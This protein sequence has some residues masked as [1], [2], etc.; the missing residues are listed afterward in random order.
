MNRNKLKT[1]APQSRRDFIK[2]VTDRAAFYGLT[3]GKIE[4][5]IEQGDVAVIGGKAFP[6][7]VAAKRRLLEQRIARQGFEQVME[8]MAY[9]WFNR[10][11]AI[12]YMELH[13]YLDHG[14]RVLSTT[15]HTNSTNE[16]KSDSSNSWLP[17]ILRYAEH[18][19][20]PGLKKEEVIDL[21]LQG[22]K[23]EELYRMLLLAQ[24]HALHRAMPFLFEPIDDE[25]EL[26]LPDNL[27]HSDSLI[28]KLVAEIPEEDWQEV[29]IIGWLY[30]FYI[31]EKKDQV[32][33]KVVKSED[34]PA[35]TQL[36]TPKWIVKYLVQN[37]LGRQWMATYPDS[38]LKDQMEYY[39]EPAQQTPEVQ[40]QLKAITPTELNPE[41]LTL[42]DPAC[43]SGHILVEA[44]DL[45][46]AIYQ[47]RGYRAKDIP[48]LILEKNLYGLEIDDRAAQLAAFA[49]M[50]KA[51]ADD[52]RIFEA[53]VQP[54]VLAIQESRGL[55]A[56]EITEALNAPLRDGSR[57]SIMPTDVAL[58][59]DLFKNGKTYGS[60]IRVPEAL[61]L[62]CPA[63]VQ[64]IDD[65][66]AIGGM[67]EQATAR[68]IKSLADQAMIL[69]RR[70]DAVCANPPYM[71]SG[72]YNQ[73][74]KTFVEGEFPDGSGDLYA[75]FAVHGLGVLKET[76]MLSLITIPT[77]L[78]LPTFMPLRKAILTGHTIECLV[79]NGRGIFGPDFGS[80]NFV[81][82]NH[83]VEGFRGQFLGLKVNPTS[84]PT[85][86]E[87]ESR[88]R[89]FS[90][91][92]RTAHDF[93]AVP[94]YAISPYIPEAMLLLFENHPS[95][96]AIA[97]VRQGVKTGDIERFLR[98]WHEVSWDTIFLEC[99]SR[100][101]A[102][103]DHRRWYPCNKG[104][105]FRRWFGNLDYVIDWQHDGHA[106]RNFHGKGGR[107]RSRP[108]N[109]SYFFRAGIT[110]ST[111][112]TMGKASFRV[113]PAGRAFESG[114]STIF[115]KDESDSS[116]ILGVLNSS[117]ATS[118]IEVLSPK[119]SLG[120]GAVAKIPIPKIPN[121]RRAGIENNVLRLVEVHRSD[122][123]S[124]EENYGFVKS[125]LV[126]ASRSTI[127][128]SWDVVCKERT[129][130]IVAAMVAE[131]GI[132]DELLG[133]LGL[134]GDVDCKIERKHIT[135]RGT[136]LTEHVGRLISYGIGC[137]MGRYSLDQP[138]LIYAHSGNEGFDPSR[139][140]KFPADEDGIIPITDTDW[141]PDD[142]ANRFVQFIA[143][144]WPPEHLEEN[145]KFVAESLGPKK[146]ESPRDTIRRY[147]ATG[148]FKHHMKMYKKRP[149]YWL[150]SSGKQ[151]AFECLVYLHRY[152]EGTLA[153]MRTEY[154]IPLQG[155]IDARIEQLKEDI[156]SATSTAHGK[157][158]QKE[159]DKLVKQ[160]AELRKFDE[161]L[162]HYADQ[163]ITL[164]LDD[165]VKVNYGKFGDLL[166]E[167]KAVTGKKK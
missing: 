17:E 142:A 67:L 45:L 106:I 80:C 3:K 90:P 140:K 65:V 143:T 115:P 126:S 87:L 6:K 149:I 108:Q 22:D 84:V 56:K 107:L 2:A 59:I 58:I 139:Y 72:Y 66:I 99:R 113:S 156:A 91:R 123:A 167:V 15:N 18:V 4:P 70:Y 54:H 53:D 158:L 100:D 152:N 110:W 101:E 114:G 77:W 27:L 51:R 25:T 21:K 116:Y 60:L 96:E 129:E 20:L 41:E 157:R 11:V 33:G 88:F 119:V 75:A 30:Q 160:Q 81:I 48:R 162:R 82:R 43:G 164:D 19:D 111:V 39:I 131:Q 147:L 64:R 46:K 154:V 57:S 73:D 150:F 42:L 37:S 137:M 109:L 122:W 14:Y 95:L 104:G 117:L 50:M 79:D 44:Y 13:G 83:S 85:L 63:I 127:K 105:E 159:R 28:R 7:S 31:S 40:E 133:C 62:R 78:F 163:R 93:L 144:A 121:E 161:K 5:V 132:N 165:G 141:F 16:K 118:L 38:P 146:G 36:F 35:A 136:E 9:T 98:Y 8:A 69:S 97:D 61:A 102:L 68:L 155:K 74:L 76:G 148:F 24:C 134:E 94:G 125:D 145:L 29:E 55:D 112:V 32:I 49:L 92:Q 26:L 10:F 52:R 47:E 89:Q 166:A 120:E 130:A 138:G 151:R 153:R 135:L 124:D 128:D 103:T 12:R 23:D 34:I 86:D 1:Y 71:G